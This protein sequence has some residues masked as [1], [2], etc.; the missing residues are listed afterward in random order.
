MRSRNIF[1]L[2][3]VL[4]YLVILVPALHTP[5]QSDDFA[6]FLKGITFE[7]TYNHYMLWSGRLVTD[8]TSSLLLRYLPYTAYEMINAMALLLLCIFI[9]LIPT[10]LN[11]EKSSPS[12]LTLWLVFFTY[13]ISNPSLGQTSFW[14]VGSANYLWTILWASAYILFSFYNCNK[15]KKISISNYIATILLGL[16]AGCSNEN[17]SVTLVLFSIFIFFYEK[18]HRILNLTGV[19]SVVIGASVMLFAPGNYERKKSFTDW[20]DK[21][22]IDQLVTHILDRSPA[23]LASYVHAYIIIISLLLVVAFLNY[24]IKKRAWVYTI[25]FIFFSFFANMILA[26]S[27]YAIGRNLNTGLFFLLPSIAI[28]SYHAFTD[29]KSKIALLPFLY[30]TTFF[31]LSYFLFT[32]MMM[33]A[34]IQHD[35]QTEILSKQKKE[36]QLSI[37]LPDWFFTYTLKDRDQFDAFKSEAMPEYYNVKNIQ[38]VSVPFNYAIIKTAKNIIVN[39]EITHNIL[40]KKV[41]GYNNFRLKNR[42]TIELSESIFNYL[43][44]DSAVIYLW[45]KDDANQPI[46][47]E[48]KRDNEVK[49][50]E[51]YYIDIYSNNTSLDDVNYISIGTN[52]NENKIKITP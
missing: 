19:V 1:I 37:T 42:I 23:I 8:F 36:G 7:S 14:I 26:K 46:A 31:I 24:D 15:S 29:K 44:Q 50:G 3:A 27:P 22:T 10:V 32:N 9:S 11:K 48:T 20:Y 41:Y 52:A 33:Q 28:L 25:L 38:W 18:E 34:K 47:I 49:I 45:L 6:Y 35:I 16:L 2:N 4:L 13:W 5:M 43:N 39:K 30:A 12:T 17:T 21:S 51:N 40:I